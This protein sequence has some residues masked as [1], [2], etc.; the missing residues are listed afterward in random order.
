MSPTRRS[1]VFLLLTSAA[2]AA[3]WT[4]AS[5]G[6]TGSIPAVSALVIDRSTGSTLYALT[7]LTPLRLSGDANDIFNVFK[8]TDGGA[9]WKALANIAR[10]NVLAVD[11]I[12]ASTTYAGTAGGLFKSTDGGGSWATSLPG[13]SI[14]ELVIDPI[15][16]SNLYAAGDKLYRSTDAGASWT[17]LSFGP[18]GSLTLDPLTPSTLYGLG[19]NG[20]PAS[21]VLYKSTDGGQSWSLVS[22][23]L[24]SLLA[25]APTT[26]PTLYAIL[27]ANT[28]S[29]GLSKSADGGA[30][31]TQIGFT[32][33]RQCVGFSAF[34]IDPTNPNTAYGAT[35]INAC[36]QMSPTIFKSTDGGQS[37][38]AVD[39][40][41]PAAA[42]FVFGPGSSTIYAATGSGVFKSTDGGSNCGE[43]NTGLRVFDIEAL[44]GDPI[45]PATVYAGGSEGLFKSVDGGANWSH[46]YTLSG[47]NSLLINFT[48]SN[49][50]YARKASPNGCSS[51][52]IDLHKSTDGGSIWNE[53]E[54]DAGYGCGD[55]GT[56]AMDPA[57][58]NTLY[59]VY[60]NDYDG[61]TIF[62][63]TDGGTHWVNLYSDA[64]GS[65][66]QIN[67]LV[68]DPNTPAILYA[69][70]DIGLFRST[71]D[72]ASFTLAGFAN[73]RVLLLA[74][75]PVRSNV[76]YAATSNNDW[77][78]APAFLGLYKSTDSG[79]S[80]S[81]IN[82]G[83][84]EIVAAHPPVNALLVD[85]DRPNVLYLATSGYGVIKSSDGGATWAAFN[86]GL[87]NLDVRSLALV[88][89]GMEA[90]GG[91]RPGALSPATLYAGTPGG[92]FKIR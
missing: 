31:W 49:I 32:Q 37:W 20:I 80:W 6:L 67:A 24:V 43:T 27:N 44:V 88:R 87:T 85:A 36:D 77:A 3:Q 5:V 45:N 25:I 74:I 51:I 42:S 35:G 59:V 86:N 57:D 56:M 29:P 66:D 73:T 18:A 8:S 9:S 17:A 53:L 22:S 48:N 69:P 62:K 50:L 64:L 38:N 30:T 92:V 82:Q 1:T 7:S 54:P 11:P 70:T 83:L 41:I 90:H 28:G 14:R 76:L 79:A 75:D 52:E 91:R 21:D 10:V 89:P 55:G 65:P 26:P 39:T 78:G 68:I 15:T 4:P 46:P 71:D 33:F 40:I 72:G 12:S 60:G 84:D 63:T 23:G 2:F 58:P 16:P 81:P 61:F 19:S 47:A 34:A 13:T